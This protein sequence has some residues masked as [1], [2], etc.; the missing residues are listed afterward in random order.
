[1]APASEL[2]VEDGVD[3]WRCLAVDGQADG[4]CDH[5]RGNEG[6]CG[7]GGLAE[8]DG[9]AGIDE[10]YRC[11]VDETDIADVGDG[12]DKPPAGDLAPGRGERATTTG[13]HRRWMRRR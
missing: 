8:I 5:D 2:A 12:I 7:A 3:L 1:M 4:G 10:A 13:R 9:V 6:V 11:A